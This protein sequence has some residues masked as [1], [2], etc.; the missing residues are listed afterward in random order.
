MVFCLA[1]LVYTTAGG[2]G[3]YK[4]EVCDCDIIIMVIIIMAIT[5]ISVAVSM[6]SSILASA[7]SSSLGYSPDCFPQYLD[8]VMTQ[9]QVM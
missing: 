5:V 2:G 7:Q 3:G 4:Y 8:M 1:Y 6:I 9:S